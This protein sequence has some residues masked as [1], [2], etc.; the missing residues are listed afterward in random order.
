[1]IVFLQ[2][3]WSPFFAGRRWPRASWL[4]A[5]ERSRT[6]KRLKVMIDDLDLCE[7]TTPEVG[8]TPSSKPP[9]DFAHIR[10]VL[11]RRAPRIVVACGRQAEVS[12]LELWPGPLLVVP[13]PTFRLLTDELYRQARAMLATC[14]FNERVALRQLRGGIAREAL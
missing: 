10:E 14:E 11:A 1:M 4:R 5:L 2:N 8:A 7:E 6:G 13:H 3:A 9:P 12:L